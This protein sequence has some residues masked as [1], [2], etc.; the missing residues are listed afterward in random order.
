MPVDSFML[1]LPSSDNELA[2]KAPARENLRSR[3]EQT[4]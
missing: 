1:V 2:R 3:I 4:L